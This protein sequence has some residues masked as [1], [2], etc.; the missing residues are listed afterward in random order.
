ML[1]YKESLHLCLKLNALRLFVYMI[2][3]Y[4]VTRMYILCNI[5]L[6]Y[7]FVKFNN[8]LFISNLYL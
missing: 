3:A 7:L 5:V 2:C 8:M 1:L 6:I 4:V